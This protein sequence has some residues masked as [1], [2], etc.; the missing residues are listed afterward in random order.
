MWGI[1]WRS[2][3]GNLGICWLIFGG[4]FS[5]G[6]FLCRRIFWRATCGDLSFFIFPVFLFLFSFPFSFVLFPF[7]VSFSFFL[8]HLSF[9]FFA[10]GARRQ[11][12]GARR[13][14]EAKGHATEH[15]KTCEK[16]CLPH[17][18][19]HARKHDEHTTKKQQI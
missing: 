18:A 15:A 11:A 6:G 2:L 13:T 17:I 12:P 14:R 5:C 3:A 7:S 9:F 19:G 10:P 1:F 8:F 16:T 4:G